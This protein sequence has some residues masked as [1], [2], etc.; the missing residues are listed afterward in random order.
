MR[1]ELR[2]WAWCLMTLVICSCSGPRDE[3]SRRDPDTLVVSQGSDLLTLDPHFI[4]E[5]PSFCIQRNI[6][7]PLTDIDAGLRLKPCLAESWSRDEQ[8]AWTFRLRPGVTFHNGNPF[9]ASDAVYSINRALT[10]P[11]SRVKS[12]IPTISKVEAAGDFAVLITTARPDPILPLRLAMILMLDRE[13][14]EPAIAARGD[15]WLY[16]HANGTGPYQVEEWRKDEHC[17]LAANSNYW[18]D[19]R[20]AIKRINFL[21]TSE[22]ATRMMLLQRGDIDILV[23]VPPRYAKTVAEIPGCRIQSRPGLRLIY[24]GLDCGRDKSPGAPA[25]PPNPLRD[26]RVR[27]AIALGIDNALIVKTIMGGNAQPAGQLLPEG[28]TGHIPGFEFP[29]PDY[30]KARTL[31]AEAG[32]AGG[33]KLRLDGPNDRYV[34]D[35]QILQAVA[36]QLARIGIKVEVNAL[37][38]AQFF[39]IERAGRCSFFLSGWSNTNG[40]GAA[41]FDHL[42]H[43]PNKEAGL[44]GA[45]HSTNYSN[46]ELDKLADAAATEFDPAARARDLERANRIAM[47]DLPHIPLHFQ[48]DLYA[49]SDRVA[50]T[51]RRETQ[52]RG[53]EVKWKKAGD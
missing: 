31:L 44:G 18:G 14:C 45:N 8:G 47:E 7:D 40:D 17:I 34:N 3:A 12:E 5:S 13:T 37:P 51:P 30:A 19:D 29:R 15:D 48:M 25:S 28:V 52:I 46:P 38:K 20:P 21:A 2:L 24:L 4:L 33:F 6:F 49:V 23:N 11:G 1:D 32:Y 36:I 27:R 39:D 50:W 35:K 53:V 43:T 10:W 16:A 42:L 41:T 9:T 22:D 26:R